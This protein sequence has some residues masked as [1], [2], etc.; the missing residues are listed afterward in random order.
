M[1]A[2]SLY[3]AFRGYVVCRSRCDLSGAQ[4]ASHGL[5]DQPRNHLL[6]LPIQ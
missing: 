1:R 4:L 2:H 3:D 5:A 6:L